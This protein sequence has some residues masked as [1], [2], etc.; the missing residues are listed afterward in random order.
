M[1]LIFFRST[2]FAFIQPFLSSIQEEAATFVEKCKP[3]TETTF[4]KNTRGR[5]WFCIVGYDRN[6]KKVRAWFWLSPLLSHV[7]IAGT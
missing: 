6:N 5:H 3:I 2:H 4:Q 7:S 1:R